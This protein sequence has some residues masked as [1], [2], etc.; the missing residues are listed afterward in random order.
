MITSLKTPDFGSGISPK[1]SYARSDLKDSTAYIG[2]DTDG[3]SDVRE[4]FV[5]DRFSVGK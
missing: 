5:L 3:N 4:Y 2:K 1:R